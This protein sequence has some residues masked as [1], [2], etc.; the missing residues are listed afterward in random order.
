MTKDPS[1][2]PLRFRT[3]IILGGK[4]ATGFEVPPEVVAALGSGKRPAVLVTINGHTYRSTVAVMG[5]LQL[6]PLSA[7]NRTQA[8]VAAGDEVDV[9]LV[10]DT[11]P[12]EVTVP[13][14]L[15]SALETDLVAKE[16]FLGLSYSNKRGFVQQVEGAKTEETRRRR[17]DKAV[18]ALRAGK[19]RL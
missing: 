6:V 15:A 3:T 18:S 19:V 16:N 8:G 9:E 13:P 14:D 4:T 10:L 12:R 1:S 11:E 7:E 2:A 5:G 17:I